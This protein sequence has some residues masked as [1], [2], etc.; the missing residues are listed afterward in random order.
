VSSPAITN[1]LR[2]KALT[3]GNV[4]PGRT[5]HGNFVITGIELE[6]DGK[7]LDIRSAKAS[8]EQPG[9]PA[10][11]VI[12]NDPI[13]G[14]AIND[15]SKDWRR[16][17]FIDLSLKQTV[18]AGKRIRITIHQNFGSNHTVGKIKVAAL[19]NQITQTDKPGNAN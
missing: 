7:K 11:G 13:T 15:Q 1:A 12:D 17:Q 16:D 19:E 6:A 2:I 9:F 4:G 5:D 18:P 14:W 10:S 8:A 3:T